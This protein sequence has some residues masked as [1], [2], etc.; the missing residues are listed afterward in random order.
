MEGLELSISLTDL[1][2]VVQKMRSEMANLLREE[3]EREESVYTR[4][5]F[6]EIAAAFESKEE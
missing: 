2:P 1:A 6:M 3:A 5:R 4:G